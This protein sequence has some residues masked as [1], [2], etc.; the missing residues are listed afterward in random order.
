MKRDLPLAAAARSLH[1]LRDRMQDWD[2]LLDASIRGKQCSA[3]TIHLEAM[4]SVAGHFKAVLEPLAGA[5]DPDRWAD[6]CGDGAGPRTA[7]AQYSSDAVVRLV[8]PLSPGSPSP[9][10]TP[11]DG[12]GGPAGPGPLGEF[13]RGELTYFKELA[14]DVGVRS[15]GARVGS[16]MLRALAC[17]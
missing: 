1:A 15:G 10:D 9:R 11:R 6:C 3:N 16:M 5:L 12:G 13:F 17:R 4:A 7:A 8:S 14:G 2:E